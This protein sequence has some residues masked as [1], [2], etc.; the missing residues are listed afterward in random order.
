MYA[1]IND[2]LHIMPRRR[3][4]S[5]PYVPPEI[6]NHIIQ[7]LDFPDR[8]KARLVNKD[9]DYAA[10]LSPLVRTKT[11]AVFNA[12]DGVGFDASRLVNNLT[13]DATCPISKETDYKKC[14]CKVLR[15]A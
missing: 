4:R 7:F 8:R 2:L 10:N 14:A 13:L 1:I 3:R 11:V 5:L 12:V 15:E 9:W 6:V